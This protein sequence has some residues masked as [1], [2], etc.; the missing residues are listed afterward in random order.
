MLQATLSLSNKILI[1]LLSL[2]DCSP[3]VMDYRSKVRAYLEACERPNTPPE[4]HLPETPPESQQLEMTSPPQVEKVPD[5]TFDDGDCVDGPRQSQE[6]NISGATIVSQTK[7]ED[8]LSVTSV[9]RS[10][11]KVCTFCE[12]NEAN[13]AFIHNGK[14]H[15]CA[16]YTCAKRVYAAKGQCPICQRQASTICKIYSWVLSFSFC[17]L[18]LLLAL[19]M[20]L[21]WLGDFIHYTINQKFDSVAWWHACS[22]SVNGIMSDVNR[23]VYCW[24]HHFG[25][26]RRD[27]QIA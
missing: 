3:E 2:S 15:L 20:Q 4:P 27:K 23:R 18:I 24:Q 14:G 12:A 21:L 16:C 6:S 10:S 11:T 7:T 1:S 9:I 5:S 22:G 19:W 26:A 8:T 25:F 17:L 13:T